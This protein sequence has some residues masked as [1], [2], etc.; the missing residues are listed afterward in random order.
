MD[1]GTC[2]LFLTQD[3]QEGDALNAR[4]GPHTQQIQRHC[5]SCNV[6]YAQLDCPNRTCWYV[7]AAAPTSMIAASNDNVLRSKW[8]QHQVH[9]AFDHVALADPVRGIFGATPV[10][11]MHFALG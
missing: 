9:N 6:R 3:M 1:I 10:E 4:Y 11:I 5:R 7:F 2:I 8:S